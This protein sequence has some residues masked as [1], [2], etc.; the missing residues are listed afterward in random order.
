M[1][2]VDGV[3]KKFGEIVALNGVSFDVKKG[4]MLGIIGPNGAGKTT[5]FNVI[6]GFLKPDGGDVRLRGKSIV[7]L[8]P[9]KLV[10]MGLVRTFQIIRVFKD[11]TVFENVEV[12]S[13]DGRASEILKSVGLWEKREMPAKNLS[14][15]E[16]RRLSIAMAMATDPK[17]LL[18]DEPFSGL[19]PR[20]A[21]E[22]DGII[23]DLNE[24]GIT[25]VI[26][27]HRLKELFRLVP[28]VIVLNFG[29][30]IF[31]GTPEEAVR[32]EEVVRAYLGSVDHVKG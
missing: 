11:L 22:L 6:S 12:A 17:V 30:V 1:L 26:I 3:I 8:K 10:R 13:V 28:R 5:L 24:S 7:G 21:D 19:S 18:L 29:R 2:E 4:E 16:L 20:E 9:S 32:D 31:E 25:Q 23:R 14:Q 15:G 27:E